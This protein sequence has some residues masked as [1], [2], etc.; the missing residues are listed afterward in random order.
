MITQETS[1]CI[2][3]Q[4]SRILKYSDRMCCWSKWWWPILWHHRICADWHGC[5]KGTSPT[6][7]Q[8]NNSPKSLSRREIYRQTRN[9][10]K[11]WLNLLYKTDR[12]I[13]GKMLM[14]NRNIVVLA[15]RSCILSSSIIAEYLWF[16][17]RDIRSLRCVF[18]Q[19]IRFLFS[20]FASWI[21]AISSAGIPLSI[22]LS[23]IS[24]ETTFNG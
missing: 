6:V 9:A 22:N 23:R 13:Y 20:F 11:V 17:P 5:G 7:N 21:K 14:D 4:V 15:N 19:T 1:S 24:V 10:L 2:L 18:F 16:F 8:T 3:R 12:I